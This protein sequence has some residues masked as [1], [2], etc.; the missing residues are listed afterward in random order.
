MYLIDGLHLEEKKK[1]KKKSLGQNKRPETNK[2]KI[3]NKK[4]LFSMFKFWHGPKH[5]G[6]SNLSKF[7]PFIGKLISEIDLNMKI[8]MVYLFS[9][10]F[11]FSFFCFLIGGGN[12]SKK[13]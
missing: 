1:K 12:E 8:K 13:N 6:G 2:I 11:L 7:F 10:L 9:N 4:N 3:N 5:R